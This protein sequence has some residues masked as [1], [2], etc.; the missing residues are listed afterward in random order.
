MANPS[1]ASG[2][3]RMGLSQ[4]L[5]ECNVHSGAGH[6]KP[7]QEEQEKTGSVS[8][9]IVT[10]S[11][12]R[13]RLQRQHAGENLPAAALGRM[14]DL[15][16]PASCSMSTAAYSM[17]TSGTQR[18]ERLRADEACLLVQSNKP[19]PSSFLSLPG[20]QSKGLCLFVFPS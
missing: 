19:H 13:W 10:F 8:D 14:G 18:P 11:G 5:C 16:S 17:V 2:V 9:W 15:Q 20:S 7:W 12:S 3:Q 1:L 6:Q 4:S